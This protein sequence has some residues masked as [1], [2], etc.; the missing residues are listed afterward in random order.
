MNVDKII[1]QIDKRISGF[2]NP[3]S[4]LRSSVF[5]E[6]EALALL[7]LKNWIIEQEQ[8]STWIK[9]RGPKEEASK[10]ESEFNNYPFLE[11]SEKELF[12]QAKRF[13]TE[14]EIVNG[15]HLILQFK[16]DSLKDLVGTSIPP[17]TNLELSTALRNSIISIKVQGN[18]FPTQPTPQTSE[19]PL[20]EQM[21]ELTESMSPTFNQV[22][23][24]IKERAKKSSRL[25]Y[26]SQ[27]LSEAVRELLIEDGFKLS[28]FE[29]SGTSIRW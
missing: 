10:T 17:Y 28:Q 29:S 19:Q 24:D 22:L 2:K 16:L 13:A 9:V 7:D 25:L 18:Q 20:A 11:H 14:S 5:G 23:F 3:L 4:G 6:D 21:S 8:H 26:I 15:E 12:S 27:S 1:K